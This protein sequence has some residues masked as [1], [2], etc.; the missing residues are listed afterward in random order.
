LLILTRSQGAAASAHS[1]I[2]CQRAIS[3]RL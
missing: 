3:L 1:P 2:L